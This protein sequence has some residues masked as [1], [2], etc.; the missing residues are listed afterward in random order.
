MRNDS[1]VII[2]HK[3]H[4]FI[5]KNVNKM[6]D[7]L[8]T[9]SFAHVLDSEVSQILSWAIQESGILLVYC[10]HFLNVPELGF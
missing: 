2:F 5:I 9:D 10:P 7:S 6:N 3:F 4:S 1:E 8:Y